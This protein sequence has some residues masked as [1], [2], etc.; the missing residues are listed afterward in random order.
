[1]GLFA[2]PLSR[3][4]YSTKAITRTDCP[5]SRCLHSMAQRSRLAGELSGDYSSSAI[6]LTRC[7]TAFC[8]S[9]PSADRVTTVPCVKPSVC[10]LN[11]LLALADLPLEVTVI[12]DWKAL[13]SLTNCAAG[14]VCRPFGA[15]MVTSLEHSISPTLSE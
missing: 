4:T 11:R 2:V 13:A 15:V 14:R 8:S 6:S 1:M 10:S 3:D 5:R 12:S 9:S 7:S